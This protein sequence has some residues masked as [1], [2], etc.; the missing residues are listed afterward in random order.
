MEKVDSLF[1]YFDPILH[2]DSI[3]GDPGWSPNYVYQMNSSMQD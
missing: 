2:Y 3:V 1:F